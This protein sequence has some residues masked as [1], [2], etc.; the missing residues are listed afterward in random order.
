V[1]AQAV[2]SGAW[3]PLA[4]A[5]GAGVVLWVL[6]TKV[7]KPSF[8]VLGGALG[9]FAGLVLV[10]LSPIP[11]LNAAG[12][13]IGPHWVGMGLGAIV[14][15]LI[16]AAL[17]KFMVTIASA[18]VFAALGVMGGLIAAR[19]WPDPGA[20]AP[21]AV[22]QAVEDAR[23]ATDDALDTLR[24]ERDAIADRVRGA[25]EQI[26]EQLKD[27][28]GEGAAREGAER[29]GLLTPEQAEAARAV[30]KDARERSR[31]FLDEVSASA[32]RE[33]QARSPRDRAWVLG[34]GVLGFVTGLL[35][36]VVFTKRS[37]A[38]LTA[39]AGSAVWMF[40]GVSLIRAG[41]DAPGWLDFSP[42][43]W[44]IAWAGAT[45]IGLTLQLGVL[46]RGE[47]KKETKKE[48]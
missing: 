30:I 25:A 29:S 1:I 44:A 28:V 48:D 8:A 31:E 7:L 19:V 18:L 35:A 15:V 26:E 27:S 22:E 10:P 34:G 36:G 5:V 40:A 14:G 45:I 20:A 6:G 39:M 9:G 3:V 37:T 38:L 41:G 24:D 47:K 32:Q 43:A 42:Q 21:G 16:S 13:E 17:F 12:V 33:W 4:V 11:T 23:R 2:P 46:G